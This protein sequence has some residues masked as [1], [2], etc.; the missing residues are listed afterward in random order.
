MVS[1]EEEKLTKQMN[2]N[3]ANKQSKVAAADKA[4]QFQRDGVRVKARRGQA[5]NSHSLAERA[6][7]EKISMSMKLLQSLVPGC[8]QIT[9]KARI[10]D[11]IIKY[12]QLL[13]NQVECLTAQLASVDLMLYFCELNQSANPSASERLCCLE[14][15]FSSV[16]EPSPTQFGSLVDVTPTSASIL[17]TEE[18]KASLIHQAIWEK[19]ENSEM[20]NRLD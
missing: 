2:K 16:L 8:D 6:R 5:T 3:R 19:K 9:G 1:Q 18:Q 11:E 7:R 17:L 10:L 20:G 4:V 15:Q 12:V 14:P 13:Q